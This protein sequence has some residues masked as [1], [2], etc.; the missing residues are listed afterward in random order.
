MALRSFKDVGVKGFVGNSARNINNLPIGIK[1]PL[2]IDEEG[3]NIFVMHYTLPEQLDDNLRNLILTN[4]GERLG[5]YSLGANLKPLLSDY[6]NKEDFETEA[7]IRINTAI[8]KY[9]PFVVPVGFDSSP[10]LTNNQS[11]AIL[12]IIM[13]YAVPV[14]GIPERKI[15]VELFLM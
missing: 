12:K 14:A 5:L 6:S 4:H 1:T 2:E 3:R 9:L 10:D 7:M 13:T 15:E 11:T 8:K